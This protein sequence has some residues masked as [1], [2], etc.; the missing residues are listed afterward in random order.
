MGGR[1]IAFLVREG[2]RQA[3]AWMERRAEAKEQTQEHPEFHPQGWDLSTSDIAAS[4]EAILRIAG[5][6]AAID[7]LRSWT[8]RT[9]AL[10][11]DLPFCL[12]D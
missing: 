1:E 11:V 10:R 12:P 7:E 6:T 3:R 2:S 9:V 8:P 4:I 5:P